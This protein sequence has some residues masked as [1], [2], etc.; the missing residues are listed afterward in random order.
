MET[1]KCNLTDDELIEKSNKWVSNLSETYG[2]AWN[3]HIPVDFNK[4]P[5]MLFIELGKRLKEYKKLL[6]EADNILRQCK[7]SFAGVNAL[8]SDEELK[9]I[10]LKPKSCLERQIIEWQSKFRNEDLQRQPYQE[11]IHISTVQDCELAV[12][13]TKKKAVSD[14]QSV[15]EKWVR[16]G[17]SDCIIAEFEEK[18][19]D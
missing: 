2:S 17:D 11:E 5:D 1:T 19:N 13:E 14:L 7:N 16:G 8:M 9:R 6:L 4:D 18:L 12:R 3:L 15:L 10:S